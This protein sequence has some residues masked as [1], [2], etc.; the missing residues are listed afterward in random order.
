[1]ENGKYNRRPTRNLI[2]RKP[3]YR[4]PVKRFNYTE[5]ETRPVAWSRTKRKR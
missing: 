2:Q 5:R 3:D 1:M 4:E